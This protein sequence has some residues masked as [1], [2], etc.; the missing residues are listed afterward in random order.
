D[1]YTVLIGV[2]AFL[3]LMLHGSLWVNLKSSGDLQT[4]ARTL[5]K[6]LVWIAGAAAVAISFA[7]FSVQPQLW[8]SFSRNPLLWAFPLVGVAGLLAIA[9]SLSS[10]RDA[11]AFGGSVTFIAG[12]LCSAAFGLFPVLLPAVPDASLSLTVYNTGAPAYGLAI[13]FWWWT[14]AFLLAVGYSVFIYH[15]FRGKVEVG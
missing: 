4:R 11:A 7:S 9:F 10:N 5:A 15:R 14:P 13:G 2:T 12:L 6:G 1:W 3:V 8:T